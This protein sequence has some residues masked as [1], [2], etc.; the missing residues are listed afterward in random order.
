MLKQNFGVTNKEHFGMLQYFLKWSVMFVELLEPTLVHL[1]KRLRWNPSGNLN[2]L[3]HIAFFFT[4]FK[5]YGCN[6]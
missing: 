4:V 3:K 1:L 5:G 2:N 6:K